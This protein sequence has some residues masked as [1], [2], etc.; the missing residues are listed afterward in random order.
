MYIV[1]TTVCMYV[2]IIKTV[3]VVRGGC[4]FLQKAQAVQAAGGR[5]V[6][7]GNLY[8]NIFRLVS[9]LI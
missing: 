1:F 2:C 5:A 4:D 7:I 3:L 6:I 8:P 9:F